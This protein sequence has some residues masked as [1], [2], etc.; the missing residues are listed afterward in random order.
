MLVVVESSIDV[1][2]SSTGL[3]NDLLAIGCE[4]ERSWLDEG[5]DDGFHR[6]R[7][8]RNNDSSMD[9]RREKKDPSFVAA[10]ELDIVIIGC[11]FLLK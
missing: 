5:R 6:C 9:D 8:W 10:E 2:K 7:C 4:S 11:C 1:D 3:A